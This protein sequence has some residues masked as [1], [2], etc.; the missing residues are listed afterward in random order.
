[1]HTH[2]KDSMLKSRKVAQKY[3]A[4]ITVN[5]NEIPVEIVLEPR[6]GTRY[7]IT[8]KKI[9]LRMPGS[10]SSL[11]IQ[12]E[13]GRLR[14]WV[15]Q[16]ALKRPAALQQFV[17]KQYVTGQILTV[18][19]R[20]YQL[21]IK[22]E[23]RS[24]HTGRLKGTFIEIRLSN[25]ATPVQQKKAVQT[26]LSRVIAGD[27]YPEVAQRVRDV[28]QRTFQKPFKNVFLKHNHSNWGSCSSNGNINLS[29]RLLFAP[30]PVQEYVILHELA[31]L[32]EMNHSDRFWNL[33]SQYMPDYAN[34]EKWLK[35]HGD[36]C[37]F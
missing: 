28:N 13:L 33:I 2:F 16:V 12:E 36:S 1:M 9:I 8:R 26:L 10:V 32:I 5:E 22:A 3:T 25:K 27:F 14:E 6:N 11:H 34:K 18:G 4:Q 30:V 17:E 37:N 19:N 35:D 15:R 31:H 29:T 20:T 24:A 23:D 21:D 7:S